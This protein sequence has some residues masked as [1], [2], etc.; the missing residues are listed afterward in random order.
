MIKVYF[1][2]DSYAELVAIF[3]GEDTYYDCLPALEKRC[4]E[5]GF[6]YITES[7][8]ETDINEI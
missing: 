7:L 2:T 8:E 3:D 5:N 4:L 6:Q 1:E